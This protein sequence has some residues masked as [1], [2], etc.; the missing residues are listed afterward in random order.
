[1]LLRIT[2]TEDIIK[3]LADIMHT[4]G[5]RVI[6]IGLNKLM[7]KSWVPYIDIWLQVNM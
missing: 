4:T 3:G 6:Y 5:R 7:K 2:Q 1:M